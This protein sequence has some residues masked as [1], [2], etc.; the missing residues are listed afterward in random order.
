MVHRIAMVRTVII[1]KIG[2]WIFGKN[3]AIAILQ[4]EFYFHH[5]NLTLYNKDKFSMV[6]ILRRDNIWI[7]CFNIHCYLNGTLQFAS[8]IFHLQRFHDVRCKG[9]PTVV[10]ECHSTIP[11]PSILPSSP[12]PPPPLSRST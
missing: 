3:L 12:S 4:S 2:L 7:L 8:S 5:N 1:M 6:H 10:L 11:P 9:K